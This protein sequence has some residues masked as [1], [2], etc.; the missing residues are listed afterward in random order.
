MKRECGIRGKGIICRRPVAAVLGWGH[1]CG[2]SRHTQFE[3][4]LGRPLC[5][6]GVS[7]INLRDEQSERSGLPARLTHYLRS[8]EPL[9]FA[10]EHAGMRN[11]G[12]W[13]THDMGTVNSNIAVKDAPFGRSDGAKAR[14]L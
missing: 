11:D 1:L 6:N 10:A 13:L 4:G 2:R 9:V 12:G 7:R 3:M 5:G 8:L 14:R